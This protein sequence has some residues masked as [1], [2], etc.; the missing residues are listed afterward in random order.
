MS[1]PVG[2][3]VFAATITESEAMGCGTVE[4]TLRRLW[5]KQ[6]RGIHPVRIHSQIQICYLV[7]FLF[8]YKCRKQSP[9]K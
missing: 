4:G 5:R 7:E 2:G 9:P 1:T 8:R 6:G 3:I